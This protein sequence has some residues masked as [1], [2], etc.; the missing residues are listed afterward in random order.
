MPLDDF[1]SVVQEENTST[2]VPGAINQGDMSG[3]IHHI[4]FNDGEQHKMEYLKN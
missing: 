2:M 4:C 3:R 1:L